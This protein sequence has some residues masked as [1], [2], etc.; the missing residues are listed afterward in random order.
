MGGGGG[1]AGQDDASG[2]GV[3]TA[4]RSAAPMAA[5]VRADKRVRFQAVVEQ[6]QRTTRSRFSGG[7]GG[8][9][10]ADE[11]GCHPGLATVAAL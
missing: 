2:G 9:G 7:S 3:D 10:G 5:V 8:E 1:G 4:P 6:S 11:D